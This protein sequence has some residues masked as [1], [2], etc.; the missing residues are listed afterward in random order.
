MKTYNKNEYSLTLIM[1]HRE[2]ERHFCRIRKII[3]IRSRELLIIS[4]KHITCMI[5]SV[6]SH[7]ME[8]NI[9]NTGVGCACRGRVEVIPSG[10]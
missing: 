1:H 10:R 8:I 2:S 3:I 9:C 5:H 6:D 4:I 7:S